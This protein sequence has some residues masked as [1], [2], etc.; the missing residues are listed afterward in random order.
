MNL[1]KKKLENQIAANKATIE[2]LLS[3]IDVASA[4]IRYIDAHTN[5][6]AV[7]KDVTEFEERF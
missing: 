5:M 7:M 3:R 2:V 1:E 6:D 4:H